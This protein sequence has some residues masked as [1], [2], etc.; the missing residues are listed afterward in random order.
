MS[1]RLY[2]TTSHDTELDAEHTHVNNEI[3]AELIRAGERNGALGVLGVLRDHGKSF[4][5]VN[6]RVAFQELSKALDGMPEEEKQR[7]SENEHFQGL[8]DMTI[9]SAR[10]LSSSDLAVV[11][12]CSGKL[13]FADHMLTDH[14][15]QF[16]I[17]KIEHATPLDIVEMAS[18]FAASG[19]SPSIIIFE[20]MK[21]K[22]MPN[23]DQLDAGSRARLEG[24][25]TKFG[26]K[27]S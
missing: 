1:M 2:A 5:E 9:H 4:N 19:I 21:D 18:G 10:L 25:F 12:A 3:D 15:A 26:Y 17:R 7:I 22:I 6:L 16:M 13:G 8:V 14:L 23:I 11:A 27:L 24:A 20:A